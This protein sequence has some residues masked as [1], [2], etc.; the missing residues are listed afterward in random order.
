MQSGT[1]LFNLLSLNDERTLI[2]I[3]RNDQPL[4]AIVICPREQR[5]NAP[6][7]N[8]SSKYSSIFLPS[9]FNSFPFTAIFPRGVKLSYVFCGLNFDVGIGKR[10]RSQISLF[11]RQ[12]CHHSPF[13]FLSKIKIISFVNVNLT[14]ISSL[15]FLKIFI[16]RFLR[17]DLL[18]SF[19]FFFL[20][21]V[22]ITGVMKML[23]FDAGN[24]FLPNWLHVKS[25]EKM[26]RWKIFFFFNSNPLQ[27]M[28]VRTSFVH[29]FFF[30]SRATIKTPCG[31]NPIS[32]FF[33]S[34]FRRWN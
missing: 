8:I 9:T 19:F 11:S 22:V 7:L 16:F 26:Q 5:D 1:L 13:P 31:R 6:S 3:N 29:N 30:V 12:K 18:F 14:A 15:C 34:F 28:Y 32:S 2:S 21:I 25:H 23:M 20:C 27:L 4:I 24:Y 17:H 33:L 10:S